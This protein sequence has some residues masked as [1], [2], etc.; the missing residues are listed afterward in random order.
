MFEK[1]SLTFFLHLLV[2][3]YLLFL[4]VYLLVKLLLYLLIYLSMFTTFL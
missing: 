1:Y 2:F 4:A 3:S